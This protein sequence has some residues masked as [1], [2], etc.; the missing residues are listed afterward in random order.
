MAEIIAALE[1]PIAITE[2]IDDAPATARTSRICAVRSNW[3][4]HQPRVREALEGSPC[5]DGPPAAA[6]ARHSSVTL[7]S[8]AAPRHRRTPEPNI[9]R[10]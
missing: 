5:R 7:G 2:C 1:G 9:V 10:R 3:Q 4:R 8:G 6:A